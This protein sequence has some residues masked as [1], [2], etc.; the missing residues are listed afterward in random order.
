M[1]DAALDYAARGWHVIPVHGV[2]DNGD[3]TCGRPACP[4][5]GKHPI[6]A[7][8][9]DKYASTDP[10]II[11]QWWS[12]WPR[13][14][15]G[16]VCGKISNLWVLD[17]D[18]AHGMMEL[19][20][21]EE[22][23]PGGLPTTARVRTGSGGLHFFWTW[24]DEQRLRT[25]I[26]ARFGVDVKANGFVVAAPSRHASGKSYEWEVDQ[27]PIPAPDSVVR[28]I[29]GDPDEQGEDFPSIS[30]MLKTGIEEGRR[31]DGM[32]H[33]AL[34]LKRSGMSR[35]EAEQL[36]ERIAL[37]CSPPFP[38]DQARAK[39]DA[40]WKFD[41]EEQKRRSADGTLDAA[42]K[43]WAA[44]AGL[45]GGDGANEP[46]TGD[47]GLWPGF[48]G[49][50]DH[51]NGQRL[52][53]VWED[54]KPVVGGGW[55]VWDGEVWRRQDRPTAA[56]SAQLQ[57]IIT[58]EMQLVD[59]EHAAALA[60]WRHQCGSTARTNAAL[61]MCESAAVLVPDDLDRDPWLL[62][63]ANG[64][65][66]LK[67]GELQ[68]YNRD[69]LITRRANAEWFDGQLDAPTFKQTLGYGIAGET[70]QVGTEIAQAIQAFFGV[71]LTGESVKNFVTLYGPGNTGKSSLIEAFAWA[72]GDYAA[73]APRGLL[74]MKRGSNETHPTILT[75]LEGRRFVYASEPGAGE[76]LN[77][78]LIKDM[79]GGAELKARRMRQD[80]YSFRAEAKPLIDTNHPLRLRDV[81][82]ALEERM[83]NIG[84]LSAVPQEA[85]VSRSIVAER[86]RQEANGIL[87][88]AWRGLQ[89]VLE[90]HG[91][92]M[93]GDL[94]EILGESLLE[95]RKDAVEDQDIIA[96]FIAACLERG[97]TEDFISVEELS[98]T[99][100]F[101]AG[102]HT[103]MPWEQFRRELAMRLKSGIGF[104]VRV[105]K[106]KGK[107]AQG[108]RVWG[109]AGVK[110]TGE[111]AV[112]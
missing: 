89:T 27:H 58:R 36:I 65:L 71:C 17:I 75:E 59:M 42:Q 66:N 46:E 112:H 104:G 109:Y 23:L 12:T 64:V 16:I 24:K 67:T 74:T 45:S 100:T 57:E 25:K 18:G 107:D 93:P 21:F 83:I 97:S 22:N 39:I 98:T 30:Q 52:L 78:E 53:H 35:H 62:G 38:L 94:T 81:S 55:I 28:W 33:A 4:T 49:V 29:K 13:A 2:E 85:R 43:A 102:M 95:E 15:I 101:W 9:F 87:A 51:A 70:E 41:E 79:T 80:F 77:I 69:D 110:L 76:E 96:Q 26:G 92:L 111:N 10:T 60:K 48:G 19:E 99:Y 91:G 47:D 61:Q 6:M 40:A 88:W 8:A 63:V 3:C 32:F 5:P 84:L 86:L 44:T 106:V 73:A 90:S 68:D 11:R 108:R 7:G 82:P 105:E 54:A 14:N 56:A 72:L 103:T 34:T 1:Q 20:E 37:R 31:D 50:T